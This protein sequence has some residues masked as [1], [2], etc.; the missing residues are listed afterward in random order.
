MERL[1]CSIGFGKAG[2]KNTLI[3]AG[4]SLPLPNI[5]IISLFKEVIR[6]LDLSL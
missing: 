5:L 4:K 1:Y 2:I 6:E 3:G